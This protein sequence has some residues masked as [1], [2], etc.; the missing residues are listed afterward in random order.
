MCKSGCFCRSSLLPKIFSFAN[1]FHF[2]GFKFFLIKFILLISIP[3]VFITSIRSLLFTVSHCCLKSIKHNRNGKSYSLSA[4]KQNYAYL[5]IYFL[6]LVIFQNVF[7]F[8]FQPIPNDHTRIIV[9][10]LRYTTITLTLT[11]VNLFVYDT[12]VKVSLYF[13]FQLFNIQD[14]LYVKLSTPLS[15]FLYMYFHKT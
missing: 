5:R 3:R 9:T 11:F 1:T 10:L 15:L 14:I 7:Y 6:T 2:V 12:R 8:V 13:V 4:L